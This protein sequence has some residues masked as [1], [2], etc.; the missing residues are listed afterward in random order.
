M[1]GQLI[2]FEGVD[3]AGKTTQIELFSQYLTQR[4]IPNV[5]TRE[6]GGTELGD[7]I[8]KMILSE[9]CLDIGYTAELLLYAAD[10]AQHCEQFILPNL[11]KGIF[12]LCDR[13]IDSTVAYQGFGRGLDIAKIN[14]INK[15]ATQNLEI[16][17]TIFLDVL[18]LQAFARIQSRSHDRL[19]S[20][21][22]GFY[23]RVY[24]GFK[25][26]CNKY[27]DRIVVIDGS[28][29]IQTVRDEIIHKL[30]L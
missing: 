11:Q 7:R 29:D 25:K 2:T 19:E 13:F 24:D 6:P 8:R 15:I 16:S 23:E 21:G 5:I 27:C 3:G 30:C 17:K 20:A 1:Q 14:K 22:E 10:R 9:Q 4:D 18:P 12:V 26:L 28:K